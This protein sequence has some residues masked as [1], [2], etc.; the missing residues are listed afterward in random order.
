ML[1]LLHTLESAMHKSFFRQI[2]SWA[3]FI[4]PD[5]VF[6]FAPVTAYLALP[7][8]NV[9]GAVFNIA[10]SVA[11]LPRLV[12]RNLLIY[13]R[14]CGDPLPPAALA[15]S[16]VRLPLHVDSFVA[17]SVCA[18]HALTPASFPFL[19]GCPRSRRAVV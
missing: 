19:Q 17:D 1:S 13:E 6:S 9:V 15:R 7:I 18:L 16:R 8:V 4:L 14:T 11:D 2:L 5:V 3:S 12:A 10:C